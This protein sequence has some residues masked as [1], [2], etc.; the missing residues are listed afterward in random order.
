ML[1]SHKHNFLFVHIAKTGGTS[2]R[3]GL[4]K[5]RWG[6]R[7]SLPMFIAQKLSQ[8]T[9]HK[10]AARFPR[11]SKVI[12][13]KEM[14]PDDYFAQLFK[15]AF[16][17]NPWDLQ[18]SSYHHIKRERPQ[19][20]QGH[21]SFED[22]M[23]WKFDP[24]RPYQYHIDTSLALQSD[25]LIDL[26]GDICVD[27]IGHYE[28]LQADFDH[29]CQQIGIASFILPHKR[30][31]KDRASYHSYYTD[32]TAGLVARHFKQDIALLNYTFD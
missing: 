8:L 22:F 32:E 29:I 10:I 12:A 18:V 21:D 30:H 20:M 19:V 28:N 3:T 27:Y 2:V 25:Y 17:R 26:K 31:A 24:T 11:H 16:V 6:H 4:N 14:L 9:D 13:A 1:L 23:R 7:Y 15:F 5:Y